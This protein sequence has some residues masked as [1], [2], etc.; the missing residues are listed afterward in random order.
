MIPLL[1]KLPSAIC[2]VF[3]EFFPLI[4]C[5]IRIFAVSLQRVCKNF[6]D[7]SARRFRFL[8]KLSSCGGIIVHHVFLLQ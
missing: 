8:D 6:I 7:I 4:V 3:I 1:R 5:V 2:T